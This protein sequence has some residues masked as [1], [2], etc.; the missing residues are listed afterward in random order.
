MQ[1]AQN[2]HIVVTNMQPEEAMEELNSIEVGIKKIVEESRTSLQKSERNLDYIK[3][4]LDTF[5]FLLYGGLFGLSLNLLGSIVHDYFSKFGALYLCAAFLLLCISLI[6]LITYIERKVKQTHSF[7]NFLKSAWDGNRDPNEYQEKFQVLH[8]RLERLG[9]A[10][11]SSENDNHS[12]I[13]TE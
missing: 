3:T 5:Y 1:N 11:L 6:L 13:E 7:D 12:K 10:K 8:S 4:L 9:R 2:K